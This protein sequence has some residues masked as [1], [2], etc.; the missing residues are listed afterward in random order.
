MAPHPQHPDGTEEVTHMTAIDAVRTI[1]EP[2]VAARGF[3]IYDIDQHGPVLR[4][5][6]SGPAG[7]AGP[8]I[9][10]LGLIT[11]ELSK[12]LDD[13]D[14][15][16]GRYTLEVSSPGLE[17]R[18]RVPE[19]YRRAVGETVSVKI[20]VPGEPTRRVRGVVTDADDTSVEVRPDPE[21]GTDPSPLRIAYD[22]IDTARTVFE[23]GMSPPDQSPTERDSSEGAT[24]RSD[25]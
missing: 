1:A 6:V 10:D 19:H 11:K 24:R 7:G 20:R 5:T 3:E 21:P 15:I 4:V 18:L 13:A 23:W 25:P 16:A 2:M 14:P 9:D 17:R 8:G 22:T 12:A